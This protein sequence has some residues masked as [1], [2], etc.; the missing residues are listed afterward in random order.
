MH[1][2]KEEDARTLDQSA[3]LKSQEQGREVN[4]GPLYKQHTGVWTPLNHR[5]LYEKI[6]GPCL[7]RI[8]LT[9]LPGFGVSGPHLHPKVCPALKEVS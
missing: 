2:A 1:K 7:S 9:S 4:S 5:P 6:A 3:A 8:L